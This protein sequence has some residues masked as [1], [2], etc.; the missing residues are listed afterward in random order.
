ME[1]SRGNSMVMLE[2]IIRSCWVL[3][4]FIGDFVALRLLV[5]LHDDFR[6][7][8]IRM[9]VDFHELNNHRGY[10]NDE[11]IR[12]T[13][14]NNAI[15]YIRDGMGWFNTGTRHLKTIDHICLVE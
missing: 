6:S 8:C 4:D 11:D 2:E 13:S 7:D 5:D 9:T 1:D 14:W 12:G 10:D 3:L 15:G